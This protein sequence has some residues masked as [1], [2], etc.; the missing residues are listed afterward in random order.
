MAVTWWLYDRWFTQLGTLPVVAATHRQ[1]IN[2]ADELQLTVSQPLSKGDRILW[3]DGLQWF[4]HEV[5]SDTTVHD[6]GQSYD[7]VAQQSVQEDLSSHKVR[8][9]V[10]NSVTCQQAMEH[11]LEDTVWGVGTLEG[12]GTADFTFERI[13]KWECL[14]QIAGA[15]GMEI[16]PVL[17]LDGSGVEARKVSLVE[18]RGRDTGVRFTYSKGLERV[19]KE[20]LDDEVCTALYGFGATLDTETDGVQDRLWCYVEDDEAKLL[21]GRPDGNGGVRHSEGIYDNPDCDDQSQLVAETTADLNKRNTP[22]VSYTTEIPFA[23]LKGVRLGDTLQVVDEEFQPEVRLNARVG[24]M[25]RDLM[26]G[27]VESATFGTVVSVLPDVLARAWTAIGE[28]TNAAATATGAAQAAAD[29][30]DPSSIMAGMNGVYETGGSYVC[31][32][33]SG[34]IITANVPLDSEGNPTVTTGTLSAVR[35][36]GGKLMKADSVDSTGAWSWEDVAL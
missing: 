29:A 6:G 24:E 7:V 14:Q 16:E 28:A 26:T 33:A 35:M 1:A 5:T 21:W 30:V 22:S 11:L 34:G 3:H 12:T 17:T 31:Q 19:T 2:G 13:S 20:V 10:A 15:F 9:W 18:K 36:S 8:L 25:T 27:D 4:E 32:T 23:S